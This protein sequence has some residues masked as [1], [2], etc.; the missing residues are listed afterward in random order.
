MRRSSQCLLS[1]S[2]LNPL[3]FLELAL[4]AKEILVQKKAGISTETGG[5]RQSLRRGEWTFEKRAAHSPR[6]AFFAE[7]MD[8]WVGHGHGEPNGLMHAMG[9]GVDTDNMGM[10]QRGCG[11]AC[12]APWRMT[13]MGER[14]YTR[15][16][17]P[18]QQGLSFEDAG[19][20]G[21]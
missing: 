13:W 21:T 8:G 16:V 17:P 20:P 6:A 15:T 4:G 14:V 19:L 18:W 2:L 5:Y 10:G 1:E 12:R 3:S 11:P 7:W 9:M